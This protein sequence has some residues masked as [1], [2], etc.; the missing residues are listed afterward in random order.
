MGTPTRKDI[1]RNR[2]GKCTPCKVTFHW[3]GLPDLRNALCPK[4]SGKLTLGFPQGQGHSPDHAADGSAGSRSVMHV[5]AQPDL[6]PGP[7][8]RK[9]AHDDPRAREL[10]DRHYSRQTHGA[11]DFTPSGRKLVLLG[12]DELS[13][14]AAV[15]NLDPAGRLQWRVTI[16]RNEGSLLSSTLVELATDATYAFWLRH[17]RELPGVP[18]TTEVDA[19]KVRRK[20]DPGRCFIRAGWRVARRTRHGLIRLLAPP[21][22]GGLS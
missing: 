14:W 19:S 20:R 1:H 3:T 18:L 4:C 7:H 5:I 11:R 8:W 2:H 15:E 9:V 16:F 22:S 13:V 6:F 17:Y 12:A 21:P 10:A